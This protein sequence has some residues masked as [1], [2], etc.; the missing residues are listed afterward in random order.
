[1]SFKEVTFSIEPMQMNNVEQCSSI[2]IIPA[3]AL[4]QTKRTKRPVVLFNKDEPVKPSAAPNLI[5][6]EQKKILPDVALYRWHKGFRHLSGRYTRVTVLKLEIYYPDD[7]HDILVTR[8]LSMTLNAPSNHQSWHIKGRVRDHKCFVE[9]VIFEEDIANAQF[10]I[11]VSSAFDVS[12]LQDFN[13]HVGQIE[14]NKWKQ[15]EFNK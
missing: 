11:K 4:E 6:F 2:S 1:M 13:F 14:V 5:V 9:F 8:Y 7:L 12:D 15:H 3:Q 10:D